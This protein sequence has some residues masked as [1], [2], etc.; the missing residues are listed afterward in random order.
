MRLVLDTSVLIDHL[1]GRPKAATELIP[2]AIA[3]G[4]ELWSVEVVRAEVLAGMRAGEEAATRDLLGLIAWVDVDETLAET[5]GALGRRYLASYPGIEITDL[6]V[7]A[8]TQHLDAELKTA[9]V[10]HFPM[11]KGLKPPY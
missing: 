3:R 6:I 8:L 5:A 2:R 11:V 10:R 1:R 7:A 9:N 4:D